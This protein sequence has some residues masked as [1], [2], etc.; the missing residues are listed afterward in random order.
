MRRSTLILSVLFSSV[1]LVA[2]EDGPN[3]TF[4]PAPPNA[5][6]LWNNSNADA[7]VSGA[8]QGFS[9]T[10]IG[11]TNAE[12]ICTG[13]QEAKRW[14]TMVKEPVVPPRYAAGLDMAGGESWPGLTIAEAEKVNCQSDSLGDI[15]GQNGILSNSWGDDQQVIFTYYVSNDVAWMMYIWNGYT[16]AM[17]CNGEEPGDSPSGPCKPLMSRDGKHTYIIPVG[18]QIQKDGA[19]FEIDWLDPVNGP[20]EL[21]E[22]ADAH[23]DLRAA[24]PRGDQRPGPV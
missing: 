11:G 16:G 6:N 24:A 15:F 2:C 13:D 22:L 5:A 18:S 10:S 21:N 9:G 8:T 20:L 3:Q 17:G 4:T 19:G 7:S 14:A 1:A 23:G 12:V